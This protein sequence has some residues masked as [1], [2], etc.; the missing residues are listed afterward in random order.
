MKRFLASIALTV[1][2]VSGGYAQQSTDEARRDP[3]KTVAYWM[4]TT[5]KYDAEAELKGLRGTFAGKYE[6]VIIKQFELSLLARE[7][8][9]MA[10]VQQSQVKRL[11]ADYAHLTLRRVAL[12]VELHSLRRQTS[13]RDPYV[14]RVSAELTALERELESMLR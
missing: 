6:S 3:K 13:P 7:M 8:D 4:L 12:E 14:V 2:F 11:S 5:R 1:A 10:C 9:K